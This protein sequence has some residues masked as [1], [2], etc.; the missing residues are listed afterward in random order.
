LTRDVKPAEILASIRRE[1]DPQ[2]SAERLV[3][4]ANAAGGLDNTTV[5]LVS[6]GHGARTGWG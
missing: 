4:L 6:I 5:I 1:K 3:E 2:A